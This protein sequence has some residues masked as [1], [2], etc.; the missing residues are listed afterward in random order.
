MTYKNKEAIEKGLV[1]GIKLSSA[2]TVNGAVTFQGSIT[3]GVSVYGFAT[4]QE[5]EMDFTEII[6]YIWNN[7]KRIIK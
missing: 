4:I 3:E 6:S 5:K 7:R 1:D 2:T